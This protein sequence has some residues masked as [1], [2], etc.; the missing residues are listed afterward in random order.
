MILPD[1]QAVLGSSQV[2]KIMTNA[3][4]MKMMLNTKMASVQAMRARA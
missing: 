3:Q 4:A 2:M 1:S